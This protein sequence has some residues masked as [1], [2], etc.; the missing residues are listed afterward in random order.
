MRK[1]ALFGTAV[2]ILLV[3][4]AVGLFRLYG[5][6]LFTALPICD[7]LQ[8]AEG[9]QVT[10]DQGT[11]EEPV[12]VQVSREDL[13]P[14]FDLLESGTVR[15]MGTLS[16]YSLPAYELVT[17]PGGEANLSITPDG[18]LQIPRDSGKGIARYRLS[19]CDQ[20]ALERILYQLTA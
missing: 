2:I 15:Y 4:A 20:E 9:F 10:A 3:L 7:T 12:S 13:E 6:R 14:L 11:G 5:P 17:L 18:W 19:G 1:K 8:S 16:Y